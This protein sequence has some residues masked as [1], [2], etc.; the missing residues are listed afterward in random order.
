MFFNSYEFLFGFLPV[1]AIVWFLLSRSPRA[2]TWW[3]VAASLFFYA[4]YRVDYLALLIASIAWNYLISL[5]I[6][7]QRSGRESLARFCLIAGIAVNLLLLGLFKYSRM[8]AP[9]IPFAPFLSQL[10]FPLGISFFTFSQIAY[11]VDVYRGADQPSPIRDYALFVSFFPHLLSGPILRHREMIPQF[12][13]ALRRRMIPRY[14]ARGLVLIVIGLAKK[15]LIADSLA[16][17]VA[18]AFDSHGMLDSVTA[19]LGSTAYTFQLYNDFSG[20]CD[21]AVGVSFL[22]NI[23][24]PE[25]FRAPYRSTSIQEFW[26]RWHIT[27][28][29]FFRN[30][31]FF[32]LGGGRVRFYRQ[33]P[34]IL[35][36]FVL[37]GLWHGVGWTFLLWGTLHGIAL[38]IQ[39]LW[40]RLRIRLP[41][42]AAWALTFAFV[43]LTWV[44]FRAPDL[45]G[46]ARVLRAMF[47]GLPKIPLPSG[48]ANLDPGQVIL[49]VAM[50]LIA[51]PIYS[52]TIAR[53]MK[54]G[55]WTAGVAAIL[56]TAIVLRFASVSYFL[57]AFF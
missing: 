10:A 42:F 48:I 53:R 12:D 55:L 6:F 35:I 15:T 56:L 32:P 38:A 44:V 4:W 39:V 17:L 23:R 18:K 5:L 36:T 57:Y 30:Y 41:N 33:L 11:L 46:A 26:Q 43:D 25:N 27:L 7:R 45:A 51:F 22:F 28:G 54:P 20:Y 21:I 24:I 9:S 37:V 34:A 49:I 8:L 2:G 14:F 52:F 50:L 13:S 19:W 29:R 1:V 31:V 16:P 47:S 40:R 3:M